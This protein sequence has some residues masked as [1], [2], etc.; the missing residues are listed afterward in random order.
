MAEDAG[1]DPPLDD[2]GDEAHPAGAGRAPEDVDE[3]DAL[4]ELRPGEA[5]RAGEALRV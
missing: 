3:E 5:A 2:G 4:H 1:A